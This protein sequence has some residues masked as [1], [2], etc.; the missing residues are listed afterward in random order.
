MTSKPVH[1]ENVTQY[2]TWHETLLP[3]NDAQHLVKSGSEMKV[4]L[5]G[6][7]VA[8]GD[9]TGWR[10]DSWPLQVSKMTTPTSTPYL[11]SRPWTVA[12]AV[13]ASEQLDEWRVALLSVFAPKIHCWAT[14][15]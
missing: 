3:N 14:A 4:G 8:V 2:V 10:P 12:R 11:W 13:G 15:V 5:V 7:A 1:D 9:Q 6:I